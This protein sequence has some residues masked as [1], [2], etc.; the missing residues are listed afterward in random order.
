MAVGAINWACCY[1]GCINQAF[2][3]DCVQI[4]IWE[5]PVLWVSIDKREVWSEEWHVRGDGIL[6][7]DLR[8]LV[9]RSLGRMLSSNLCMRGIIS[10]PQGTSWQEKSGPC[11]PGPD[12]IVSVHLPP[13]CCSG[14]DKMING[15][16]GQMMHQSHK[17]LISC[18][19][20]GGKWICGEQ[21]RSPCAWLSA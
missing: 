19:S 2:S 3:G 8:A 18:L 7:H 10:R 4:C 21:T 11:M 12:C 1:P 15:R 14:L 16:W 6:I 17:G 9:L 13:A 20:W 5:V